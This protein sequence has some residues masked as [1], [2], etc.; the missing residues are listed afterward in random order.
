M[1]PCWICFCLTAADI[2]HSGL[3]DAQRADASER[4]RSF[5]HKKQKSAQPDPFEGGGMTYSRRIKRSAA[6]LLQ[7]LSLHAAMT[8]K[9]KWRAV[10]QGVGGHMD[11]FTA[12]WCTAQIGEPEL[13]TYLAEGCELTCRNALTSPEKKITI[14]EK[15]GEFQSLV[16]AGL[17]RLFNEG[18]WGNFTTFRDIVLFFYLNSKTTFK[19]NSFIRLPSHS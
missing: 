10:S 9:G 16:P 5:T 11:P 4:P 8:A 3:F 19:D 14:L 13:I 17:Q 2:F 6:R 1:F 15:K 7:M 18:G 12:G